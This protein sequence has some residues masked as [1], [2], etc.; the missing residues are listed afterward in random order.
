MVSGHEVF[1]EEPLE[2]TE[3]G[4]TVARGRAVPW[5]EHRISLEA[6]LPA[7][8]VDEAR[9]KRCV[10]LVGAVLGLLLLAPLLALLA[11][12]VK[13]DSRGP[14]LFAQTRVGLGG[15]P[16]RMLKL[17]TMRDGA[18]NEKAAVA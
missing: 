6:T 12:F 17:R 3:I 8:D 16:F 18:D 5:R 10:D 1:G 14:V 9:L 4:H 15:R 7:L 13:L 2:E 11:I